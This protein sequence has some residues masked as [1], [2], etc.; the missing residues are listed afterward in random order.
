VASAGAREQLTPA[1]DADI[2]DLGECYL[3]H[4]RHP[5]RAFRIGAPGPRPLI[6][7]GIPLGDLLPSVAVIPFESVGGA[8]GERAL[9]EVLAEELIRRLSLSPELSVIS[10][11]S[12]TVF[13]GRGSTL[14][15]ISANLNASYVLSGRCRLDEGAFILDAELAD[16]RPGRVV[17]SRRHRGKLSGLLRGRNELIDRLVADV[18]AAVEARELQ[19][20][21][22]QALPTL[23]SYTLLLGAIALMHRLSL[24]D[25]ER[26]RRMLDTLIDRASRQAIP[27]A[28]LAKWHVLRV[29]QGWSPDPEQDARMALRCTAQALD[30]DPDC[31]LA[32]AIDGFVHTNLLKQ[33]DV[34]E[35]RYDRAIRTT[36]SEPLA[37]LLKGTLHAFRGEGTQAVKSTQRALRLSPLDPHRYFYDSLAA[38][39]HLAAHDFERALKLAERSLRANR[40][41]TSTLRAMA[42]AQWGLGRHHEARATMQDLLA[43]E[44]TLTVG[45]WRA[46]SPAAGFEIGREWAEA[47]R[48]AGLPE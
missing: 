17:W 40:T 31:S 46:R 10:R 32:L 18:S 26:A 7:P 14:A 13:Y 1:L 12:T 24:S 29:Q 19:R 35:E 42:I 34:A 8:D 9:G 22:S 11:L 45:R 16:A 3:K 21:Q 6:E 2:E 36:P 4:F 5:V 27:Q 25:F 23:K 28:W 20:A 44:P 48:E 43:L 37:W 41:H 38:T 47:L 15:E 30:T 33:L 39:A